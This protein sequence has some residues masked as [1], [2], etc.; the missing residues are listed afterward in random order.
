MAAANYLFANIASCFI[1]GL[2]CA[3]NAGFSQNWNTGKQPLSIFL[4]M[5]SWQVPV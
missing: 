2:A 3:C 5:H 4:S 1:S